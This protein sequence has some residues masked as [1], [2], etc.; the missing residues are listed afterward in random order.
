[1][2]VR[3]WRYLTLP[4]ALVGGNPCTS[5]IQTNC[6]ASANDRYS[7][8]C[9][10]DYSLLS[11]VEH[12]ACGALLAASVASCNQWTQMSSAH[13]H[14]VSPWVYPARCHGHKQHA[15]DL[16]CGRSS[17]EFLVLHFS[18]HTHSYPQLPHRAAEDGCRNADDSLSSVSV[19]SI[20]S[21]DFDVGGAREEPLSCLPG[22][23]CK[24]VQGLPGTRTLSIVEHIR[25]APRAP[26]A[27]VITVLCSRLIV[28]LHSL[29]APIRAYHFRVACA[30]RV[31]WLTTRVPRQG[32]CISETQQPNLPFPSL[33]RL[34]DELRVYSFDFSHSL[35]AFDFFCEYSSLQLRLNDS[36]HST[37]ATRIL[38]GPIAFLL[39][40]LSHL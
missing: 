16:R 14:P 4:A 34:D 28:T 3:G 25:T 10:C 7:S 6:S 30:V 1:M 39:F 24:S 13:P 26:N 36:M 11:P 29:S 15:R 35:S 17:F 21:F 9:C 27:D 20:W 31:C 12:P 5:W 22:S 40:Y 19:H 18:G 2:T 37:R 23:S 8:G 32:N 33:R 38:D